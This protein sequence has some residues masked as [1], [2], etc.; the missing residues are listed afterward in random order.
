[1]AKLPKNAQAIKDWV[2][3]NR[4]DMAHQIDAIIED[5]NAVLLLT[6]GFEAGRE[7]QAENPAL[8]LNRPSLYL[9]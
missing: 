5:N 8:E 2:E 1:M 7:F 6:I 4:P 9:N 3:K